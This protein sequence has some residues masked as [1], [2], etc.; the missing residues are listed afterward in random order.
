MT[1]PS[2]Y[3]GQT[4]ALLTQ[5]GKERIL[6][7]LLAEH[8]GCALHHVTGFDTDQLGTFTRERP[9]EGTQLGAA[10]RK[11]R[12]G[13]QLSGLQLGLASEG[14][15]GPDPHTGWLPWN[16]EIVVWIDDVRGLEV[17]GTAQGPADDRQAVLSSAE[18]LM[19]FANQAGFPAHGLVL[20]PNGPEGLPVHKDLETWADLTEAF[21][22]AS[23]Q[24]Q[25][26]EVFAESD[27]R[28]HRNP[29]RQSLI[30]RAGLDLVQRLACTCPECRSPGFGRHGHVPGLRCRACGRRTAL[31]L[32]EVWR[33][34][35]CAHELQRPLP[36]GSG[37]SPAQCSHCN[38]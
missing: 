21:E 7:P 38:P 20:R 23:R 31:P 12:V 33:C 15:F 10:R 14:S 9:R 1:D 18:Q 13:M 37:A 2:T 17:V 25:G 35:S 16:V 11:A 32:A 30:Q 6:G 22:A 29:T 8:L 27:L 24:S 26:H 28:A 4:T 19:A 3:H 5:H 34:V 36:S